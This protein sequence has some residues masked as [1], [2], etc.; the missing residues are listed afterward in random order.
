MQSVSPPLIH[1]D[2]MCLLLLFSENFSKMSQNGNKIIMRM[3]REPHFRISAAS[4][5][6]S[7]IAV[8]LELSNNNKNETL[9]FLKIKKK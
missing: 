2:E 1:N 4:R 5:P 8:V 9:L 3:S 7:E 6:K